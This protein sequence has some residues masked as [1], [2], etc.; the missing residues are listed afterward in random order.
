MSYDSVLSFAAKSTNT[1]DVLCVGTMRGREHN[2]LAKGNQAKIVKAL[3]C[4]LCSKVHPGL[5]GSLRR[6]KGGFDFRDNG[7]R[8]KL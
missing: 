8:L 7:F 5:L 6:I 2:I 1:E 4:D 3:T